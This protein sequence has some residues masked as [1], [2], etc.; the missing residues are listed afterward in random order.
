VKALLLV[1]VTLTLAGCGG[2]DKKSD[3]LVQPSEVDS[4]GSAVAALTDLPPP[5]G[6]S[7]PYLI[8][9]PEPRSPGR[10]YRD[11]YA[12]YC[13]PRCEKNESVCRLWRRIPS[14]ETYWGCLSCSHPQ[15]GSG[16]GCP[17]IP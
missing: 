8:E 16:G 12:K 6:P 5:S 9:L 13:S 14:R 17:I 15:A 3:S 2:G 1:L 7:A 4:Y 10:G 11:P